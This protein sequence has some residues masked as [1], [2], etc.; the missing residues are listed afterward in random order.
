M[1]TTVLRL[2]APWGI[3]VATTFACAGAIPAVQAQSVDFSVEAASDEVRRGLSWSDGEVS[4]S[5]DV[6]VGLGGFDASARVAMLRRS[7]RHA[8]AEAV[9]DLVLGRDWHAGA[10]VVRTEAI[11][12]LFAGADRGMDYYE[13]GLGARYSIGPLEVGASGY[14]AP[15]QDA[16]GGDNL[17]LR[18]HALA[19]IPAFPVSLAASLGHS[20]GGSSRDPLRSARLRPLGSY[21]DW[22]LGVEYN[23]W[24]ISVG[25]DYAGNDI[26]T[27]AASASPFADLRHAGDRVVGRVRLSF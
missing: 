24:P 7:D 26:A 25:L 19:G 10:L 21:T 11:S 4:A 15:G 27:S 6:V 23:R 14:Y 3:L 22:K 17:H 18:A 20:T 2:R 5:S 13:L 12:H 8:N 16:I 9:A 1:K